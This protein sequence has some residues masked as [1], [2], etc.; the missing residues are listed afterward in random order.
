MDR[1]GKC[2]A[3]GSRARIATA[4]DVSVNINV[5]SSA[6]P[7]KGGDL[8]P[9][10]PMAVSRFARFGE[11]ARDR[12][13]PFAQG[14][15]LVFAAKLAPERRDHDLGHRLATRRAQSPS[16]RRGPWGR[17]YGGAR[18]GPEFVLCWQNRLSRQHETRG[19]AHSL[20]TETPDLG[21]R[22][23]SPPSPATP[24]AWPRPRAAA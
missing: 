10:R 18:Q 15:A 11:T 16:E 20:R 5:S 4:A 2:A 3:S 1:I 8:V 9:A 7:P 13:Q 14:P 24:P 22:P 21:P 6:P 12:V 23:T 19:M 17:G